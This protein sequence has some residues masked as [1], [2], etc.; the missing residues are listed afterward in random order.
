MPNQHSWKAA[1]SF[2]RKDANHFIYKRETIDEVSLKLFSVLPKRL[3]S[4]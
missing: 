2:V 3:I 4:G 1:D